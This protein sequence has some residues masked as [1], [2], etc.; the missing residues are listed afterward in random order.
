VLKRLGVYSNKY[1]HPIADFKDLIEHAKAKDRPNYENLQRIIESAR[2][3]NSTDAESVLG[4]YLYE[5]GQKVTSKFYKTMIIFI[6][7]YLECLND[8][9]WKFIDKDQKIL[10]DDH[11]IKKT[12]TVDY[13]PDAGN[14]FIKYYLPTNCP[15]F[16]NFLAIEMTR[17]L[18]DWLYK[19]GYTKK[20]ILLI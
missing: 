19:N 15:S 12:G 6:R 3:I 16:N 13:V 11:F 10:I 18:C 2:N 1:N 14:D 4:K 5:L 17:H 7:L 20:H 8:C 9:G